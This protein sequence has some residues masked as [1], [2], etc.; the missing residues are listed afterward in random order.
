[1]S[2]RWHHNTARRRRAD[3]GGIPLATIDR[4][5]PYD[6]ANPPLFTPSQEPEALRKAAV[7]GR[8]FT[9]LAA[10]YL[11]SPVEARLRGPVEPASVAQVAADL[12]WLAPGDADSWL[13][14]RVGFQPNL[15]GEIAARMVGASRPASRA[16]AT[17]IERRLLGHFCAQV[18]PGCIA[19]WGSA[20][21][22]AGAWRFADGPVAKESRAGL[23][24]EFQASC[25][26]REGTLA[27]WLPAALVLAKPAACARRGC[28]P[29]GPGAPAVR[30]AS[31]TATVI[32]GSWRTTT[33]GL[34]DLAVGDT[35]CLGTPA[36]APLEL[37]IQGCAG[38]LVRPGLCKGRLAVQ[39]L[40]ENEPQSEFRQCPHGTLPVPAI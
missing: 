12:H 15:A 7:L 30:Q 1:M 25:G 23:L 8:V 36:E 26:W 40:G 39:V 20:S 16:A 33:A 38:M 32:L 24:L 17:A 28:L 37:R 10:A 27:F 11:G 14:P 13:L 4:A 29:E 3:A 5:R 19:A 9:E 6:L 35:L 2:R 31:V 34:L 18:I 21:I 22:P